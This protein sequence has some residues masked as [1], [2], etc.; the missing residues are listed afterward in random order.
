MPA[1]DTLLPAIR[2]LVNEMVTELGR[3]DTIPIETY[4]EMATNS[5]IIGG[6]LHVISQMAVSM[7]GEYQHEDERSQELIRKS[8]EQ[9]KGSLSLS[10]EELVGATFSFG[11]G[12]S[13]WGVENRESEVLLVDI[14]IIDPR[15][16]VF[17]GA[18]GA[19]ESLKYRG[20]KGDILIPYPGEQ[21][22]I[23]H[24]INQRHLAF[25]DPYGIASLKRAKPAWE[26]WKIIIAEM[27]VAAQ[28]QATPIIVGYSDSADT[29]PLYDAEGELIKDGDGNPVV[30][31]AP[32]AMLAQL[33]SLDNRSVLSTDLKNRIESLASQASGEFFFGALSILQQY[34]L[35]ALLFPESI[36]TATGVGDSNLNR[37]HRTVLTDVVRSLVNQVKEQTLESC[38][39]WLLTWN[40][41]EQENYGYFDEPDLEQLT[42]LETL[43]TL[44]KAFATGWL[45]VSNLDAV[46]KGLNMMGLPE[47]QHSEA[48]LTMGRSLFSNLDYW[49]EPLETNG[50]GR[51]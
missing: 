10:V 41:G 31:E 45:P 19:I 35:M 46:N 1:N 22:R 34:Q 2:R 13:N 11:Y 21:G 25:R 30:V 12:S 6:A 47:I 36:L 28:R 17:E 49:K 44:D 23:I 51:H 18:M 33:E 9:M 15:K 7:V 32:K 20:E 42:K 27:L 24:C 3:E 38:V 50:N 16:Y 14:Q 39:K 26:A 37:G 43:T 40:V 48:P 5:P 8:F 29:V 4:F